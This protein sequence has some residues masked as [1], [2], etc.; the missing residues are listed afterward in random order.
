MKGK[1]Q[2]KLDNFESRYDFSAT[3]WTGLEAR[4]DRWKLW[5][6]GAL[7][8]LA[9][10]FL[11]G[12]VGSNMALWYQNN[13][14]SQRLST[15]GTPKAATAVN[16]T[17]LGQADT[18]IKRTIIYQYDTI[19]RKITVVE[20]PFLTAPV[21][22]ISARE[23]NFPTTETTDK[24]AQGQPNFSTIVT[25]NSTT[26]PVSRTSVR[27]PQLTENGN[28]I[29]NNVFDEK[30]G[31]PQYM[32]NNGIPNIG[33]SEKTDKIGEDS[34][35]NE[36]KKEFLTTND[37]LNQKEINAKKPTLAVVDTAASML[38]V[39]VKIPFAKDSI[40]MKKRP[41]DSLD[42]VKKDDTNEVK[43]DDK[44]DDKTEKKHPKYA[45]KMLPIYIG[46]VLGLPIA[47]KSAIIGQ[48]GNQYGFKAEI[49]ATERI[50]FFAEMLYTK[51]VE[52]KSFDL[53]MLPD[54]ITPP[55]IEPGLTFKYWETYGVKS[56]NYIAGVQY[57]F[58][59][60]ETF[61]PYFAAAFNATSTLPFDID[62]EYTNKL[63]GVEKSYTKNVSQLEH[64][65]R[66]YG[67]IGVHWNAFKNGQL[68]AETY[69]TT[70]LD[71]DKA[72]TPT[73]IGVKIGLFYFI[74]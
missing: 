43:S 38:V 4:L 61:H 28:K 30:K 8:L 55:R 41:F 17:V 39:E 63:T 11:L 20:Q 72:L 27:E 66:L 58:G 23:S 42:I 37:S 34:R 74:R 50:R 22:R 54:D 9:G 25:T 33:K 12:S 53:S 47:S 7:A 71:D 18:I 52:T 56:F 16:T 44:S 2:T 67:A 45:F 60:N 48:N 64:L 35:N 68:A 13:A 32:T 29:G 70:S 3:E 1:L 6:H 49:V 24:A 10:L 40:T 73:Q 5:R 36:E 69:F 31:T 62:F 26:I 59:K 14:L 57:Q 19:Y 51:N 46:G 65:N 15:M 21:S